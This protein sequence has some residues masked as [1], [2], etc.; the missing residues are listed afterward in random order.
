MKVLDLLNVLMDDEKIEI[1][2]GGQRL[3]YDRDS[4]PYK[5]V[6]MEIEG[7]ALATIQGSLLVY[8][9]EGD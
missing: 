2:V 9:T 1:I 6:K 7:V 3:E 4:I 5:Y 8:V